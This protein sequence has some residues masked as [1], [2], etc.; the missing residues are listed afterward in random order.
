MAKA[1]LICAPASR[2]C[3]PSSPGLEGTAPTL[4]SPGAGF[5]SALCFYL[6]VKAFLPAVLS[7]QAQHS[8]GIFQ[9]FAKLIQL[10]KKNLGTTQRS[11]IQLRCPFI[12]IYVFLWESFDSS[13]PPP[14]PPLFP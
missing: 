8:A 13:P 12:L 14:P 1:F 4:N 9:M 6:P 3:F 7:D 2:V 10:G 11:P 5:H